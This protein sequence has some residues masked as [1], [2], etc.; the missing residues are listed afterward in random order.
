MS[1]PGRSVRRLVHSWCAA[2]PGVNLLAGRNH[3]FALIRPLGARNKLAET[4][5]E[6]AY[7]AWQEHGK[8]ALETM[9][10]NDPGAKMI[11]GLLPREATLNIGIGIVEDS[12]VTTKRR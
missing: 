3:I 5:L 12:N 4:F 10:E 6:D 8:Q 1:Q 9:A 11:S 2:I 7:E